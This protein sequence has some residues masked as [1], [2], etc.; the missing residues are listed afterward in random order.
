M[1]SLQRIFAI[2]IKELR[3]LSRDRL[4]FGMIV[5]IPALQLVLFGY[6]I[7]MDVRHLSAGVADLS[8]TAASRQVIMDMAQ[9]QV[10]DINYQAGDVFELES[11]MRQGKI[12]AGVYIPPD[13][14][15]RLLQ[16]ER[17]AIQLLVDGSDTVVQGAVASIARSA[18]ISPYNDRP[19]AMEIRTY[20]NPERRS[21]VNTV[22]GL[23]GVIL[24]MTM[25]MFTAVA[26]VRERERGNLELLITTPVRSAELMLAK[27]LPYVFIGLLQ[28]TLVLG[29]GALLFDV[30]LR[31]TLIDVYQVCLLFI[32]ANLALGLVASTIA[33]TQFQAMQ[34]TFFILLPSILLSGFIFPF[35]GMPRAAQIIAEFLP[36]THFMRLIR[37]VILRGASLAELYSEL[38]IL[39]IFILAAMTVAVLRFN[40]RLD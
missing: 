21:P 38:M 10:I 11:L 27:I 15:R 35:D 34:M 6:A 9:T 29:L 22:P 36:M 1:K 17:S 40:K 16:P 24:T 39:G 3:Q 12:V 5:G 33:Q 19:P 18:R 20:Y 14:E 8:Q 25:T 31:G 30:P 26:I 37:G 2:V 7:N 4:T 28:V 23:I 13:Y 32:I